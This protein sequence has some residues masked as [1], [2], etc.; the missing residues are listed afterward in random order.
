[1]M[2]KK[3]LD[4]IESLGIPQDSGTEPVKYDYAWENFENFPHSSSWAIL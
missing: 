1:M 4:G 2:L 3:N